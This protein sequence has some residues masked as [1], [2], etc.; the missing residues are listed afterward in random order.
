[1]RNAIAFLILLPACGDFQFEGRAE[2]IGRRRDF[3]AS[4]TACEARADDTWKTCMADCRGLDEELRCKNV[5]K[6]NDRTRRN[7][8]SGF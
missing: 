3:I 2:A 5:C 8:C 6:V 7:Q 1:M 4:R